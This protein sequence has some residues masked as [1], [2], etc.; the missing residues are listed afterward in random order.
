[1]ARGRPFG[2][3][4][5]SFGPYSRWHQVAIEP[6]MLGGRA[7]TNRPQLV[8]PVLHLA[9]ARLVGQSRVDPVLNIRAVMALSGAL[10]ARSGVYAPLR[11]YWE[12]EPPSECG[13]DWSPD[14]PCVA[15]WTPVS[16]CVAAWSPVAGKA[17][18]WTPA[19][20]CDAA[21]VVQPKPPYDCPE[22]MH[23]G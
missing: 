6:L 5:Y 9:S 4:P 18:V 3:W 17:P 20:G 10:G 14:A 8:L 13:D 12:H 15:E 1:M 23:G 19:A 22:V 11:L 21:W 16:G 2:V 7:A